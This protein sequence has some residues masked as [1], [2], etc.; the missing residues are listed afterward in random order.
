MKA[1]IVD[2]DR[3]LL[4]TDKTLSEYTVN[5]L[6]KCHNK[7]F[8]IIAATARPQRS[9]LTYHEQVGFDA[10]ITMNGAKVILPDK[11]IDNSIPHL[12]GER[13]L[14]ELISIPD[15]LVSIETGDGVYSN[16]AIPEWNSI[17]YDDFPKLP[18]NVTLY[19]ILASSSDNTLYDKIDRLLTD[20]VYYTIAN[21]TL[22]QIMSKKATKWNGIK[23][24]LEAMNISQAD[25]VYFGDDNDDIES[26]QMCGIGVAVSNA[27]EAA[28]NA[29]DHI[30][31]S[32]DEDGVA[33]C[34][35]AN[36]L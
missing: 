19:K 15:T 24:A 30:A 23:T 13:V 17:C 29:A 14:S 22:L 36:I 25:A 28:A 27:I 20:D 18:A 2:L 35:E 7:G 8:A 16:F 12:S 3:T 10:F 1:I 5:V 31:G 34:I 33:H 6:K 26:I 32:N 11:I 21:Q 9:I 4:H